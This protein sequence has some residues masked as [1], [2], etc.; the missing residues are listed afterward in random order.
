MDRSAGRWAISARAARRRSAL[1]LRR[2]AAFLE[3]LSPSANRAALAGPPR[4]RWLLGHRERRG[5]GAARLSWRARLRAPRDRHP[6]P[7]LSRRPIPGQVV[8]NSSRP[9]LHRRDQLWQAGG[10]CFCVS[11]DAGPKA[12]AGFDLALTE[13]TEQGRHIFVLEVGSAAGADMVKDL[14]RRPASE[15]E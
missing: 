3:A 2:R 8:Q 9:R 1:R 10:T 4:G 15:E 14:P 6:G 5:S 11:M 7:G 13:L 12:D